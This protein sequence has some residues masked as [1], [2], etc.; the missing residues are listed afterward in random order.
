MR[1]MGAHKTRVSSLL[2]L[3][4]FF[5]PHHGTSD[6]WPEFPSFYC[7][8]KV[9]TDLLANG[10]GVFRRLARR[11]GIRSFYALFTMRDDREIRLF[12]YATFLFFVSAA[13]ALN[14]WRKE[15]KNR[16]RDHRS[17]IS[18]LCKKE[19]RVAACLL[20]SLKRHCRCCCNIVI[21]PPSLT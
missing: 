12:C 10:V 15:K 6:N 16:I 11:P 21:T 20:Q 5:V 18:A 9:H 19:R 8:H 2:F 7:C 13:A 17:V 1:R 4:S 14:A 3:Y